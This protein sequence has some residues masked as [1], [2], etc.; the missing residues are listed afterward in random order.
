MSMSGATNDVRL[1]DLLVRW[2]ESR[3]QGRDITIE[4]LC[5]GCPELA[6]EL[7]RQI[8]TMK[9]QE[10]HLG[11]EV[12]TPSSPSSEGPARSTGS[13]SSQ[14]DPEGSAPPTRAPDP[15]SG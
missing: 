9:D 5:A 10:A 1:M 13:G 7:G 3:G 6:G 12:D 2:E 11:T 4:E 8:R 14:L 15:D